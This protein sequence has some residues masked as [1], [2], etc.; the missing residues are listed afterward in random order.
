MKIK[1]DQYSP[2]SFFSSEIQ[3]KF[4]FVKIQHEHILKH[5]KL[6][7]ETFQNSQALNYANNIRKLSK[8]PVPLKTKNFIFIGNIKFS[9]TKT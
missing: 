1:T 4:F 8:K 9:I 6:N 2:K 5:S 7:F 3:I